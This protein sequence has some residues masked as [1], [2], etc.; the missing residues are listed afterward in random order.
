[1]SHSTNETMQRRGRAA[2][3]ALAM[4]VVLWFRIIPLYRTEPELRYQGADGYEHVYLGDYDSYVWLR[5][6]R[7]YLR[8]G[9]TCDTLVG[10]ECRDT[11]DHA[12]VGAQMIYR[13]SLHIAA[14]VAVP[15]QIRR[16]D[17]KVP[18]ENGR[19]P[20]P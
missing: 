16:D 17:G 5:A 12:P 13:R 20:A 14:I 3:V 6:A 7:N 1:M 11:Y 15:G 18:R 4:L 19:Q 10:G 9:T 8:S 2:L